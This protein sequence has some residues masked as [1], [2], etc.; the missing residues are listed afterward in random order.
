MSVPKPGAEPPPIPDPDDEEP[1]T[2]RGQ[3]VLMA[4]GLQ[5]LIDLGELTALQA[6]DILFEIDKAYAKAVKEQAR[7]TLPSATYPP[8]SKR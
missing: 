3:R 5:G 8:R 2:V 1:I 6:Q 7:T 4:S